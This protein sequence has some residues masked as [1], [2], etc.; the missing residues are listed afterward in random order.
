MESTPQQA[1]EQMQQSVLTSAHRTFEIRTSED[2]LLTFLMKA[3]NEVVETR[4]NGYKYDQRTTRALTGIA[5]WLVS[6]NSKKSLRIQGSIGTGKTTIAKAVKIALL[7]LE[8]KMT[9]R[10]DDEAWRM[11]VQNKK[12]LQGAIY[13]LPRINYITAH[14]VNDMAKEQDTFQRLKQSSGIVIIDDLGTESSEIKDYGTVRTPTTEL[15]TYR[16]DRGL[17]VIIT[18]NLDNEGIRDKYGER[19]LDRIKE[20]YNVITITGES[21]RR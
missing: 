4:S 7:H 9:E 10:L 18:T 2:L 21:Y 13:R 20:D 12:D 19:I 17:S 11:T 15:I 1:L 8:V 5:K 6:R 3:H 16:Y 14:D